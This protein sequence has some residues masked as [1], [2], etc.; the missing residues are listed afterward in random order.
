M[1]DLM[2]DEGVEG[3]ED[4]GEISQDFGLPEN[5]SFPNLGQHV[6]TIAVFKYKIVVVR[7]LL[8]SDQL[9][10]MLIV[11]GLQDLNFAFEQ[12]I[13]F[14][15]LIGRVPLIMSLR[16]VLTATTSRVS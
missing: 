8:E 10:D 5:S 16:M 7:S 2:A 15:C 11:A 1:H 14:A 4:L 6:T 13:K 12:L 3:I 9:D